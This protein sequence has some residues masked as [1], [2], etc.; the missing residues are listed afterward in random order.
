MSVIL[1]ALRAQNDEARKDHTSQD[2]EPAGAFQVDTTSEVPE[3]DLPKSRNR[4]VILLVV[5][6]LSIVAFVGIM[7]WK[8]SS[9]SPQ[10]QRPSPSAVTPLPKP[11]EAT[12]VPPAPMVDGQAPVAQIAPALPVPVAN[13][14]LQIARSQYKSGEYDESLKSFQKAIERDP[15][16]AT[17]HN[18]MGLVLL[19]KELFASAEGHFAK[20]LEI[21]DACA[22]CYNNLGYLKTAL[23]QPVEAEKYLQK[24]IAL[25]PDYVDPYFNLAVMYEKNGDVGKSVDFYQEY[26]KRI[27]KT[28]TELAAKIKSRIHDLS[29]E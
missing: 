27:P 2:V 3:E 23:G 5:L 8:K 6:L 24:A 14:D 25:K 10:P 12:P 19:K 11:I 29:G 7:G 21:D 26:L 15:G 1:K 22:E 17:I 16:N 20:A 28:E 18:D 9:P 13:N 4:Q